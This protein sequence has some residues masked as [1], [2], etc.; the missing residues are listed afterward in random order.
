MLE[1]GIEGCI[2][3]TVTEEDTAEV[4]KSGTLQV[5][6]T[7][8]MIALIEETAWKSVAAELEE[9]CVTVGISL[10]VKHVSAT[11]VGMKVVCETMLTEIDGKRLVFAV[12]VQDETGKIGE[13]IHE[14]FIVDAEK[15]QKKTDAKRS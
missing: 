9:G 7:P 4:L 14:R 11:P 15:F 5:F 8:A 3:K 2:E 10:N 13:G 1:I 12:K 6:A